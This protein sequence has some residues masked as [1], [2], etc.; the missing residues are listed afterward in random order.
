[1]AF[2]LLTHLL[3]GFKSLL[4]DILNHSTQMQVVEAKNDLQLSA[5][6][7]YTLP[8]SK[9]MEVR[10]GKLHLITR[11]AV[12]SDGAEGIKV[13]KEECGGTTM[14]QKPSTAQVESMP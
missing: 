2:V 14:A 9:L 3:R 5:N 1:M 13:L 6:Q 10:N 12:G 4:P 7:I 8:A 11:P